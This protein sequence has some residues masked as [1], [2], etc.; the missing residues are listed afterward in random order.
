MRKPSDSYY[1]TFPTQN[2]SGAATDADSLPTATAR[3]NG[4]TDGAFA[5]T[6]ANLSTGLYKITGTVPAG[7]AAGDSVQVEV[8]ATIGGTAAK[9]V[10]D[11]FTID[12]KRVSDL[13]DSAYAGGA[14]ASVTGAV[15]SV[16][17]DV[18]ITQGGAD[19]VWLSATRTLSS[20]GTL[21][22]DTA[23]AVW[24]AA[25]R[26]LSAFGFTVNTNANATETAIAAAV[27]AL[28]SLG[29]G[30]Y[31]ITIAT[32]PATVG[33]RVRAVQGLV[34]RSGITGVGGTVVFGLDAG[35][36]SLIVSAPGYDNYVTTTTVTALATVTA[37]L[38]ANVIAQ[39]ADP[40]LAS[41][42]FYAREYGPLLEGVDVT[43]RLKYSEPFY[44][45]G[46]FEARVATGEY[47]GTTDADGEALSDLYPESVLVAAGVPV[48]QAYY[49]VNSKES[50]RLENAAMYVPDVG[51]NVSALIATTAARLA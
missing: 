25:T 37:T 8:S 2:S 32:S 48:A 3:Q 43:Y 47:G 19:K 21:V 38:T 49:L 42:G 23:T 14:V 40:N 28:P 27:A 6:V 30:P 22:A 46:A 34:A 16:T 51:G 4:V 33:A 44:V 20:V 35:A 7:Y 29:S 13:N 15:G 18:G 41:V 9:A 11:A 36:W 12:T 39:P 26:T 5:L 24:G 45:D 10:V 1:A 17:A 31:A 50:R